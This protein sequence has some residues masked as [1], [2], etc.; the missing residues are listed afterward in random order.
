MSRLFLSIEGR[1]KG[2]GKDSWD[3]NFNF[4]LP[5]QDVVSKL[6]KEKPEK[7]LLFISN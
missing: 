1:L 3:N 6:L 4:N 7:P 2:D 5:T